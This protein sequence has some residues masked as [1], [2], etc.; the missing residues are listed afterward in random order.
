MAENNAQPSGRAP[1]YKFDRG[2]TPAEMGPFVGRIVNT[3][4]LTRTGRL[5]VFIE[6]FASG[7]PSTNP[8][9]WRW[10]R[11][12]SP[13][14]GATEKTSTSAGVGTYPGNQQ[15]Y[16]MWFTREYWTDYNTVEFVSWLAKAI[17]IIPGLIFGISLWWLY[18]LTLATSLTLIWASNKKFLPTLV[19]FNTMWT[20]LSLMVLAQHLVK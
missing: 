8:E 16:G 12:L 5:Q 13:F 14:Y 20:W 18:F 3:V 10:V 15:S 19:G 17:I 7:Q 6:Q 9:T 1:N 2:G 11:Y 4:D